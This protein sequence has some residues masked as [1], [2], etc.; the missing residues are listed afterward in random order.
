MDVLYLLKK[1][2]PGIIWIKSVK[3]Y[4][5]IYISSKLLLSCVSP[6]LQYSLPALLLLSPSPYLPPSLVWSLMPLTIPYVLTP[7]L[8]QPPCSTSLTVCPPPSICLPFSP[9]LSAVP[10]IPEGI[11]IPPSF[12]LPMLLFSISN[13][14]S[15]SAYIWSCC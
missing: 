10:F 12:Q 8:P 11:P 2:F 6:S 5:Y 9:F 1:A 7:P 3:F 13:A 14:A 4:I 15:R